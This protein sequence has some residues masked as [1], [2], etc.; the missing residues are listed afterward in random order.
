MNKSNLSKITGLALFLCQNF[1]ANSIGSSFSDQQPYPPQNEGF[2]KDCAPGFDFFYDYLSDPDLT[3]GKK[4]EVSNS[5][6]NDTQAQFEFVLSKEADLSGFDELLKNGTFGANYAINKTKLESR[7]KLFSENWPSFRW[8]YNNKASFTSEDSLE[9]IFKLKPIGPEKLLS[10]N[11]STPKNST[12]GNLDSL[13]AVAVDNTNK[14]LKWQGGA[15]SVISQEIDHSNAADVAFSPIKHEKISSNEATRR[16]LDKNKGVSALSALAVAGGPIGAALAGIGVGIA[17]IVGATTENRHFYTTNF[18]QTRFFKIN[19]RW[20]FEKYAA[21]DAYGD[22]W[23]IGSDHAPYYGKNDERFKHLTD[24][25]PRSFFINS[26]QRIFDISVGDNSLAVISEEAV[27]FC[28]SIEE[29]NASTWVKNPASNNSLINKLNKADGTS[30]MQDVPGGVATIACGKSNDILW[31]VNQSGS[32]YK[33][34]SSTNDKGQK[35]WQKVQTP[36]GI[37]FL[38][39]SIGATSESAKDRITLI[40]STN[41]VYILVDEINWIWRK[42]ESLTWT[43]NNF[44]VKETFSARDISINQDGSMVILAGGLKSGNRAFFASQEDA[45][46][47]GSPLQG[48]KN[49][50]SVTI[51]TQDGKFLCLNQS[52]ELTLETYKNQ[53][54]AAADQ[55]CLFTL[56]RHGD[57]FG[58]KAR[59]GKWLKCP[60]SSREAAPSISA[61]GTNSEMDGVQPGTIQSGPLNLNDLQFV[62]IKVPDAK[63]SQQIKI[64]LIARNNGG[65][66]VK[67]GKFISNINNNADGNNE[68]FFEFTKVQDSSKFP[69]YIKVAESI[70]SDTVRI[71]FYMQLL[72]QYMEKDVYLNDFYTNQNETVLYKG[73]ENR[74]LNKIISTEWTDKI[75]AIVDNESGISLINSIQKLIDKKTATNELWTEQDASNIKKLVISLGSLFEES[76]EVKEKLTE[77]A[78]T[79]SQLS[80]FQKVTFKDLFEQIKNSFQ[81]LKKQTSSKDLTA[82]VQSVK[83]LYD[84]RILGETLESGDGQNATGIDLLVTWLIRET[85]KTELLVNQ[86]DTATKTF[87]KELEEIALKLI[88]PITVKDRLTVLTKIIE[89]PFLMEIEKTE[90]S[91]QIRTVL[92]SDFINRLTPSEVSKLKGL[93]E[94]AI[95]IHLQDFSKELSEIKPK[96]VLESLHR[97]RKIID[98]HT[99]VDGFWDTSKDNAHTNSDGI[100]VWYNAFTLEEFHNDVT[101]LLNEVI[102][103]KRDQKLDAIPLEYSVPI[104]L[105]LEQLAN[106]LTKG[107]MGKQSE[108]SKLISDIKDQIEKL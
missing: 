42:L 9:S 37:L 6:E 105:L 88:K 72:K 90:L 79:L 108:F 46:E 28:Q 85:S 40:S 31:A 64:K 8:N 7:R 100:K 82:F 68:L 45:A 22:T 38:K 103:Y 47:I 27:F 34:T 33:L 32:I 93:L 5:G 107:E 15:W 106:T 1:I 11:S 66:L 2:I 89:K 61:T 67:F 104:K 96:T 95:S 91:R 16:F 62:A 80:S 44:S 52:D 87:I 25:D 56:F 21:I 57:V 101:R 71:G 50:D 17:A 53:A 63:N 30:R 39:C 78:S 36:E 20:G 75:P 43:G 74:T 24:K 94:K 77:L 65:A 26:N 54:A 86:N 98:S 102:E 14:I 55:N 73:K 49:I 35:G 4:R 59:N 81:E 99:D 84:S 23:I 92:G 29:L 70:E 10:I 12:T 48:L 51:S 58:L 18:D 76:P 97:L 13:L 69:I 83:N 41:E 3:G 19:D 60:A